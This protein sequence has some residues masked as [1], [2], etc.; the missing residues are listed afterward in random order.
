MCKDDS[1]N[2]SLQRKSVVKFQGRNFIQVGEKCNTRMLKGTKSQ[3]LES[4]HNLK[5]CINV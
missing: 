3:D 1:L 4:C 5:K 2:Q